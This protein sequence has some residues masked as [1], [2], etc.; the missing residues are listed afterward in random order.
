M[1]AAVEAAGSEHG[2]T[3]LYIDTMNSFSATR[4]LQIA[5]IRKEKGLIGIPVNQ[6]LTR[7]R[8]IHAF[9]AH[10]LIKLLSNIIDNINAEVRLR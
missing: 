6:T 7:I 8:C 5:Q 3:V 10:T 4:L 2:G 1:C 9:K